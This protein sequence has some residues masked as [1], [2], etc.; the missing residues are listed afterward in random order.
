MENRPFISNVI[1]YKSTKDLEIFQNTTVRPIVKSLNDLLFLY[2]ENYANQKKTKISNLNNDE[3]E[4]FITA[5]FLKDIQFKN[6]IKGMVVG[7]F[8]ANEFLFYKNH[9]KE[10]NKR[11]FGII[12]QRILCFY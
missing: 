6:E 12:K 11:I 5:S 7:H 2:F 8:S 3:K 10:I 4:Q 1:Q 9:S